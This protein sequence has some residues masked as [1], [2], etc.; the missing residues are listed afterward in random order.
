MAKKTNSGS[1]NRYGPRYGRRNKEKVAAIE[2]GHRG[3][4][5]CPFCNYVKVK[6]ESRGI[7]FCDKC[8]AKFA[9]KAYT[10][11]QVKKASAR[12]IIKAEEVEVIQE[13]VT[14]EEDL[15]DDQ[16]AEEEKE[17]SAPES[18]IPP[19]LEEQKTPAEDAEVA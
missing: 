10:Y 19:E 18:D 1:T 14:E 8:K 12:D 6:R 15:E 4:H 2:K 5:K 16:D 3:L 9:G 13:E 11:E 7:W 17:A